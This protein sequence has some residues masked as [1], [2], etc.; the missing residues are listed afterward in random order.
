M[1]KIDTSMIKKEMQR[2]EERKASNDRP[3]VKWGKLGERTIIKVLPPWRETGLPWFSIGQHYSIK[4]KKSFFCSESVPDFM[5]PKGVNTFECPICKDLEENDKGRFGK[6]RMRHF[7]NAIISG[8]SEV[9][10]IGIPTTVKDDLLFLLE[11]ASEESNFTDLE[12]S[13]GVLIKKIGSGLETE[14]KTK[15]VTLKNWEV[16]E[17]GYSLYDL[18]EV[19]TPSLNSEQYH[20]LIKKA[21]MGITTSDTEID[22]EEE[23][24][25]SPKKEV[26]KSLGGVEGEFNPFESKKTVKKL[27]KNSTPSCYGNHG[28]PADDLECDT[29]SFESPCKILGK[30]AKK[31]V[32][33]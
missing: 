2:S 29:C 3:K 5:L 14:Y 22:T 28:N 6:A 11:E 16:P 32:E 27:V 10:V 18:D 19:F 17:G 1:G 30:R 31:E 21:V 9:C 23:E 13:E 15:L 8:T 26:K 7:I 24:V 25:S 4:T 20:K 33:E 12:S